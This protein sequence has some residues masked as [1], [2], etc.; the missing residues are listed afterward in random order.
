LYTCT[1]YFGNDTRRTLNNTGFQKILLKWYEENKRPLPWRQT[2]DPYKIW[3]SEI[4]LQQTRISQGI[5]YYLKFINKYQNVQVLASASEFE[6]L[7]LWQGLGYYSRARNMLKCAKIVVDRHQGI[8]P[9]NEKDLLKLPGIGK[10]T[11]AAIASI[12]FNL[13][14]PVIDGNVYRVLS[15]IFGINEVIQTSP[16]NKIFQKLA[17]ELIPDKNPGDYNQALM[18]FGALSCTPR[19]PDC[20]RCTF[21]SNCYA[22]INGKQGELPVIP[23]RNNSR[24]RFFH[25]WVIQDREGMFL[26]K[27]DQKDI[28]FGLYDFPLHESNLD[29]IDFT[30]DRIASHLALNHT[31]TNTRKY[32]HLLT[33]Q[34]I[35]ATFYHWVI[36]FPDKELLKILPVEGRFCSPEETDKLPK[37]GLINKYLKEE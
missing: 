24:Q 12:S 26:K 17:E 25:Y 28:W 33:H 5:P 29:R 10:Y 11:A 23:S 31:L 3:L 7:R 20:D 14:V 13:P 16:S 36:K 19:N 9:P 18:E 8:F 4:I 6:I 32:R 30:N 34:V 27:R 35:F 2:N 37:P 22:A 21:S 15:R 1:F